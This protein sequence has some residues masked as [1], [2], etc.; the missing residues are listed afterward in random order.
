MRIPDEALDEFIVIY[1]EEFGEVINRNEATEIASRIVTLYELL[2]RK[3]PEK[4]ASSRVPTQRT[5][6][7]PQ[8]GFRT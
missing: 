1:K 5:G 7:H 3:L 6:D 4:P 8:I 2:A